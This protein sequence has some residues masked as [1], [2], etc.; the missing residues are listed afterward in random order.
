MDPSSEMDALVRLLRVRM[1]C[2]CA[3]LR[4]M[5]CRVLQRH[6]VFAVLI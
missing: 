1:Q 3:L 6:G 2:C 4:A 5:Y